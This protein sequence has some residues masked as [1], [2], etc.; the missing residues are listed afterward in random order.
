VRRYF[1]RKLMT[2]FV[3]FFVAATIDWLIPRFMPGDPVTQLVAR[4][5]SL[6]PTAAAALRD[7]YTR[8]FGFDQPLPVQ[9]LNFWGSLLK[10]DLGVSVYGLGRPVTEMLMAALPYTMALLIPAITLSWLA[11]NWVGAYAA[12][13]KRL[14]NTV[15]P[16]GY[17]LTATPY[18]WLALVLSFIIGYTFKWL[19]AYG[20][21]SFSLEPTLTW[22]FFWDLVAHWF[23]PFLSLFLVTVYLLAWNLRRLRQ[24]ESILNIA[25]LLPLLLLTV[26]L[27]QYEIWAA[28]RF[29]RVIAIPLAAFLVDT[30]RV[31]RFFG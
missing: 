30:E 22:T 3:T 24:P 25:L 14:D 2:Y 12:R 8:L 28:F 31:R 23:L 19:P 7:Y 9:Y 26:L 21:Y 15:L 20:S 1:G 6:S 29:G 11:G 5:T 13:R 17:V 18:M 10:G 16:L 27:N 4:T